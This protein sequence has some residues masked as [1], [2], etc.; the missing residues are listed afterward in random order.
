MLEAVAWGGIAFG[1]LVTASIT[2]PNFT[3]TATGS[4]FVDLSLRLPSPTQAVVN[5]ML[6]WWIALL[7][8]LVRPIG[9]VATAAITFLMS[10]IVEGLQWVLPT[11]R[12]AA[13]VD[14]LLN[15]AGGVVLALVSVYLVRPVLHSASI[16]P[17]GDP[18][19]VH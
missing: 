5:L 4:D 18:R 7:L 11:G 3:T 2:L 14:V 19:E 12:S 13:L 17:S 1:V 8:P 6:F 9:V 16:R 10:L 15:T